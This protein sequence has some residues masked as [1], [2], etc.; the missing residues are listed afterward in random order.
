MELLRKINYIFNRRQKIRLLQLTIIILI[1]AFWELLGVSAILPFIDV[2]MDPKTINHKSYLKFF[3]D[4]LE[5]ESSKQF[6]IF[7][8]IVLILI[9]IIKNI[10]IAVMYDAQY[11]FTF[12]NQKRISS[13]LFNCYL[14]QEYSFHLKHNSADL[15]RNI[16]N[17]VGMFFQVVLSFLQLLTELCVCVV[18]FVFLLLMDKTITIGVT[19]ILAIFA[20]IFVK[21]F[22]K[23]LK[24]MGNTNRKY[25]A[26]MNKWMLQGFGGIKEIKVMGRENYFCNQ[27]DMAYFYYAESQR[28]YSLLGILPRPVMEMVCVTALLLVVTIKLMRGVYMQYFVTTLSVFAVAAFRMLP[29]FN[30]LTTYLNTIMFNQGAVDNVY[31]DLKLIEKL[32]QN[33]SENGIDTVELPFEKQISI[34]NLTFRYPGID[35][36]VLKKVNLQ[37]PKNASVAFIGTSGAGKTTLVDIILGILEPQE[38]TIS[39]DNLNAKSSIKSWQK[40]FGYIPQTIYIMDDTLKNNITFGLSPDKVDDEQLW[41]AIEEAQLKEFVLELPDGVNTVIGEAGMRLSGGQRQRIGIAR[42]LYNQPEILV[43]DE[44]TSALDNETE[45]AIMQA[46]DNFSGKKTMII[47]A[48]RLTTVKNCDIIYRVDHQKVV[49][50]S[51]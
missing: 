33:E 17:D 1:G 8:A 48:H 50:S 24:S 29:S 45:A 20:L 13:K 5:F 25:L 6:M 51:I 4:L 21:V 15:L 30:R 23:K 3:Y 38:G 36:P 19:L 49:K 27:Y 12:R 14:R 44:A 34:N 22:Q 35:K 39:V 43:L 28:K 40:K 10:Y 9:Y 16:S 41:N 18:L 31:K 37:I 47:I 46:I 11:K 2:L 7:L 32:S 42:V 26:E